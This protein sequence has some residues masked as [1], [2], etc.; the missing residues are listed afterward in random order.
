[1]AVKATDPFILLSVDF[2]RHLR[3]KFSDLTQVQLVLLLIELSTS[4]P[5]RGR[6]PQPATDPLTAAQIAAELGVPLRTVQWVLSDSINR[7]LVVRSKVAGKTGFS[8][9]TSPAM[10]A[11]AADYLPEAAPEPETAPEPEAAPE[12]ET[13][14]EPRADRNSLQFST[15]RRA[16]LTLEAPCRKV[17]TV[18]DVGFDL[19]LISEVTADMVLLTVRAT[20][21]VRAMLASLPLLDSKQADEKHRNMLRSFSATGS[22]VTEPEGEKDRNM[23]RSFS[24]LQAFVTRICEARVLETPDPAYWARITEALANTPDD[25]AADYF[26]AKVDASDRRR[27]E[28]GPGI[29]LSWAG[30]AARK[31]EIESASKTTVVDVQRSENLQIARKILLKGGHEVWDDDADGAVLTPLTAKEIAWCFDEFPELRAEFPQL[32]ALEAA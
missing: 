3:T 4:L 16:T 32:A 31:W 1:M 8:Y 29:L 21:K 15:G 12:P 7:G 5:S 11:A 20:D 22:T 28:F 13:A 26:A 27:R 23:L 17:Q 25:F 6:D 24:L 30:D 9:Q 19:E 14:P 2:R 18:N 10:W